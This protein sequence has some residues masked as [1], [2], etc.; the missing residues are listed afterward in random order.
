M[1]SEWYAAFWPDPEA[2]LRHL[3]S[4]GIDE[5]PE[6]IVCFDDFYEQRKAL[7]MSRIQQVLND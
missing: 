2:R 4:Q 1:P 3:Q 5:L 6:N 7:L